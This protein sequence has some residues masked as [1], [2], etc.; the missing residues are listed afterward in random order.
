MELQRGDLRIEP[1]RSKVVHAR[2]EVE[3]GWRAMA[4]RLTRSGQQTLAMQ[5]EHLLDQMS[6]PGPKGNGSL[7]RCCKKFLGD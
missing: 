6:P 5:V 4:D 3:R 2:G 1:G 7:Q